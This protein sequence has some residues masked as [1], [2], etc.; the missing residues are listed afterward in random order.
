LTLAICTDVA[1]GASFYAVEE[2]FHVAIP[3]MLWIF[4][5]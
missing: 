5:G 4:V 1:V 2:K 3:L